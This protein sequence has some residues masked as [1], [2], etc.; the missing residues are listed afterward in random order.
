MCQ[1][2]ILATSDVGNRPQGI[3]PRMPGY[4]TT[5]ENSGRRPLELRRLSWLDPHETRPYIAL[6]RYRSVQEK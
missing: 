5:A 2:P 4:F 1:D 3:E 6:Y